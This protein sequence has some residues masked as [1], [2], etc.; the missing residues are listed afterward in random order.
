[1]KK[2]I[3]VNCDRSVGRGSRCNSPST[4]SMCDVRR[5][6]V[7]VPGF[8]RH[9]VPGLTTGRVVLP[10]ATLATRCCAAATG[11][12]RS[13]KARSESGRDALQDLRERLEPAGRRADCDD[14]RGHLLLDVGRHGR[15]GVCL[16]LQGPPGLARRAQGPPRAA[17]RLFPLSG[18]HGSEE[19]EVA[20]LLFMKGR[21]SCQPRSL[22]YLVVA[23]PEGQSGHPVT[24]IGRA[25][26]LTWPTP[27]ARLR[28]VH[29]HGRP[30]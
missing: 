12:G 27:P 18:R 16:Q 9:A 7:H 24:H 26:R 6:D 1:M 14:G 8:D 13:M 10:P 5:N 19:Y 29:A 3:G 21:L 11:A 17:R 28:A 4:T 2:S 30:R 25:F 23:V 15:F 22:K 20:I